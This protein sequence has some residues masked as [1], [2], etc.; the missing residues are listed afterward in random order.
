[1]TVTVKRGSTERLHGV[2]HPP[3][4]REHSRAPVE[5]EPVQEQVAEEGGRTR[6]A[7]GSVNYAEPKLNTCVTLFLHLS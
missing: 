2:P 3:K 6:R 4:E 7:R 1:M 5:N